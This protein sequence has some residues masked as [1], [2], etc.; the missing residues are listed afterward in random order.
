MHGTELGI[1]SKGKGWHISIDVGSQLITATYVIAQPT[2]PY[3]YMLSRKYYLTWLWDDD[4]GVFFL[5]STKQFS[6]T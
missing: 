5:F 1:S 6:S 2:L 4:I 3:S